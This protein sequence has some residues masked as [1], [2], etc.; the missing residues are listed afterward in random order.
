[1][2]CGNEKSSSFTSFNPNEMNKQVYEVFPAAKRPLF[3]ATKQGGGNGIAFEPSSNFSNSDLDDSVFYSKG[4]F[5]SADGNE[6]GEYEDE[7]N[8]E[9]ENEE[10]EYETMGGDDIPAAEL[11]KFRQL[12]R[13]KKLELKAQYGKAKISVFECGIKPLPPD[14]A[15]PNV[16]C[17]WDCSKSKHTN[18]DCCAKNRQQAQ[19]RA[20][21]R[22][23][24]AKWEKC[25]SENKGIIVWGW[26]KK[27]REFKKAG[28][29]AQ[30]RMLSK[31][32]TPPPNTVLDAQSVTASTSNTQVTNNQPM[33]KKQKQK[34]E[35]SLK[36]VNLGVLK[37]QP[38]NVSVLKEL[39]S[40][41]EAENS[42]KEGKF[43]WMPKKVGIA[44]AVLG[45]AALIFGGYK[46]YVKFKK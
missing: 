30:L 13:D 3:Y 8:V 31:G 16:I 17:L 4:I 10:Y 20:E 26:R 35:E 21:Q 40:K 25:R 28:G 36:P 23:K 46:L 12:V 24:I 39:A 38:I 19:K 33:I 22:D 2:Y 9:Y 45:T 37:K 5:S 14:I 32:L 18:K 27:W 11:P 41:K 1:M 34:A 15:H 29:L 44:V 6:E 42:E 7:D 43:L